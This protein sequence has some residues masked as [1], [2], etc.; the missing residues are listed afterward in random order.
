MLFATEGMD[1]IHL[2]S[3]S[4]DIPLD[5]LSYESAQKEILNALLPYQAISMLHGTFRIRRDGLFRTEH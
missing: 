5:N 3:R 2:S 4:C 1:R